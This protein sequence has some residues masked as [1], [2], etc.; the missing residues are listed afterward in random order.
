M[1]GHSVSLPF[2]FCDNRLMV[3]DAGGTNKRTIFLNELRRPVHPMV[4]NKSSLRHVKRKRCLVNRAAEDLVGHCSCFN[5]W[6]NS[7]SKDSADW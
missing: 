7:I 5:L 1:L 6:L 2:A 3:M 4:S